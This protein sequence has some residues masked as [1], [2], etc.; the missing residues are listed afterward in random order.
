MSEPTLTP[1]SQTSAVIL[2]SS[3]TPAQAEAASFPFSV[4]TSDRFFLSGAADQVAYTFH[5]L[6]GDVLDIELTKEQIFS[7]YQESVLE[8]SYLLNIHQAKNAIGDLLGAKTG[9]FDEEGQL[10]STASLEDVAL[11]FPKFKFEYTR[12]V[13]HGYSTEAGIGGVTRIYSASFTTTDGNKTTIFN[14]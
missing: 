5:K 2:P 1:V 8:Y 12:R 3:S 6:G 11:K 10:Q 14:L 4:Y 9:S 13:G 7:S